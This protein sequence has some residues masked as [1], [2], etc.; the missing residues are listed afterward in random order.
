MVL[1]PFIGQ[2]TLNKSFSSNFVQFNDR[3][4][5]CPSFITAKKNNNQQN[6]IQIERQP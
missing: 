4:I 6:E 2:K 1:T 5:E 3:K